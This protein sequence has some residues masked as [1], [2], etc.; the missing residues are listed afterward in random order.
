M[1]IF[2]G[3]KIFPL[4]ISHNLLLILTRF[5]FSVCIFHGLNAEIMEKNFVITGAFERV[6]INFHSI[7]SPTN[8]REKWFGT[9][10]ERNEYFIQIF[11][12]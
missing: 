10:N 4:I 7:V 11:S 12:T 2:L 8:A 6:L 3:P 9:V 5:Q 1:N